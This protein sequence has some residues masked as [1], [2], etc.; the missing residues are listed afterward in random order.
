MNYDFYLILYL[1]LIFHL[2][3]LFLMFCN[4]CYLIW[5]NLSLSKYFLPTIL[6]PYISLLFISSLSLLKI[7]FSAFNYLFND[8]KIDR[9][10]AGTAT[11][12]VGWVHDVQGRFK[13]FFPHRPEVTLLL[14]FLS[15]QGW[16]L[17]PQGHIAQFP[18]PQW[19]PVCTSL[20]KLL[21]PTALHADLAWEQWLKMWDSWQVKPL[22]LGQALP[23]MSHEEGGE[24]RQVMTP[25]EGS[26]T[27]CLS[28]DHCTSITALVSFLVFWR[29]G[30]VSYS[31]FYSAHLESFVFDVC[32]LN[33]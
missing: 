32:L 12:R 5:S 2:S 23:T 9:G 27:S 8:Y 30:I 25:K 13:V 19:W 26:F 28:P 4:C 20:G 7:I 10:E 29:W 22:D 3:N 16:F 31:I 18:W 14:N 6:S 24:G 1:F 33:D 21:P 17:I 11:I 15:F